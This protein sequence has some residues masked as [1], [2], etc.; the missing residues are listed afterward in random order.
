M[1]TA[2]ERVLELPEL[3]ERILLLVPMRDLLFSQRVSKFWQALIGN[4]L[5]LQQALFFKPIM[6]FKP[7]TALLVDRHPRKSY[8]GPCILQ[9]VSP[10]GKHGIEQG[11]TLVAEAN[12]LLVWQDRWFDE[13]IHEVC[14]LALVREAFRYQASIMIFNLPMEKQSSEM[15]PSWKRM[16]LS[17]PPCEVAWV[18]Y[19]D[20]TRDEEWAHWRVEVPGG[21][22]LGHVAEEMIGML[23]GDRGHAYRVLGEVVLNLVVIGD[24][25]ALEDGIRKFKK[26]EDKIGREKALRLGYRSSHEPEHLHELMKGRHIDDL[27]ESGRMDAVVDGGNI[28]ITLLSCQSKN[29]NGGEY[30]V[31]DTA[32][33]KNAD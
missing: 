10:G 32:K 1:A 16:Y 27:V 21:V 14:P 12:P 11:A 18:Q 15:Q 31:I 19:A 8:D 25:W 24:C 7:F 2:A 33:E 26:L 4:S 17:Q 22:K 29:G 20:Y 5:P 3:L 13:E 6:K 28:P 9:A 30:A 23:Y